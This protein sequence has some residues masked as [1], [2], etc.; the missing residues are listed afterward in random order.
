MDQLLET[1]RR[2]SDLSARHQRP[3]PVSG[4]PD[5]VERPRWFTSPQLISL[6]GTATWDSLDE[7]ARQEL[8]FWEA[9]SFY[10]LNIHGE[11]LLMAG[12]A[13][14]LYRPGLDVVSEYL[15]HF[16][17]EEN[18]H[19]VWFATFCRQY[20][21]KI[22][23]ERTVAFGADERAD[24]PADVA[25]FLF[26]ARVL[27][28]EELVNRYNVTMANDDL[29]HPVARR[30][31]ADHYA[32]E[33]RHLVFGRRLVAHLWREHCAAWPADTIA[34]VR[35]HLTNYLSSMWREYYNPA[36]YLDA[37]LPEPWALAR[38]TWS[39]PVAV[40][41]RARHTGPVLQPFVDAG[42]LDAVTAG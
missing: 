12:L 23:P 29:L 35:G 6:Y 13:Q 28:F 2:L 42:V 37:G 31:N 40:A 19:S 22:Y 24:D 17:A 27:M 5:K 33:S 18:T 36:A 11:R 9:V 20:A 14:R 25:D 8:S 15:H 21:G 39:D 41:H 32:D 16:L 7:I 34:H 4:W 10:S 38:A 26:F 3:I 1:S 30:I